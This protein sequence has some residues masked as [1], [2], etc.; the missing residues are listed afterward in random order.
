MMATFQ[1]AC[2]RKSQGTLAGWKG[3]HTARHI[4]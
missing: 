4:E 3:T 2:G 1:C